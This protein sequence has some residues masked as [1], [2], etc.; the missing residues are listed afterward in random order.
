MLKKKG[1]LSILVTV[2]M[3]L[4]ACAAA[5]AADND[6]PMSF[7]ASDFFCT[8]SNAD[9]IWR[10][11]YKEPGY[12]YKDLTEPA[13]RQYF[14]AGTTALEIPVWTS[15]AKDVNR[16]VAISGD[17]MKAGYGNVER[18]A[19]RTFIA[20]YTGKVDISGI[21]KEYRENATGNVKILLNDNQIWP[22]ENSYDGSIDN[23]STETYPNIKD[24]YPIRYGEELDLS[25]QP[26]LQAV[27][28]NKGDEIHFTLVH[29]RRYTGESH[30]RYTRTQMNPT[31]TYTEASG[32]YFDK[33][34]G[35]V[36]SS[37]GEN[38]VLRAR[39]GGFD[40]GTA[41]MIAASYSEEKELKKAFV[42]ET[43]L[44]EK[45]KNKII[46]IMIPKSAVS[47]KVTLYL[48][49][50]TE[51]MVPIEE[52]T[53]VEIGSISL[54]TYASADAW[55][56]QTPGNDQWKYRAVNIDSSGR[57]IRGLIDMDTTKSFDYF[58]KEQTGAGEAWTR[59]DGA[60]YGAAIGEFYMEAGY[61]KNAD[62]VRSAVKQ[63]T[64]PY[65]GV[66]LI[67]GNA[68]AA[69]GKPNA[70]IKIMKNRNDADMEE[71][72][73]LIFP[74]AGSYTEEMAKQE[75]TDASLSYQIVDTYALTAENK[76]C[77][78]DD[79][80]L[81]VEVKAGDK[82]TFEVYNGRRVR[83]NAWA[84]TKTQWDPVVSYIER[85]G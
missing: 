68:Q 26:E 37:D 38:V 24:T 14:D 29:G 10:W 49:N 52:K 12:S 17:F 1:F 42:S 33:N 84:N 54:S 72:G 61:N 43:F 71:T 36:A 64:A 23:L 27:S 22:A 82:I 34:Y 81:R 76:V 21:V 74:A 56:T 58:N 39:V 48:W 69:T 8:D 9:A 18:F 46:N 79:M 75:I 32:V 83:D 63:F 3:S 65:D 20:P 53:T 70:N 50:S 85:I 15:D 67:T 7:K 11:Q 35:I 47:D 78:F 31:I 57:K 55:N 6:M 4:A 44:F 25:M 19:V 45:D 80:N 2:G 16:S 5:D 40:A 30:W 13:K 59:A 51:K 28:V 73:E 77:N 60:S 41:C 62:R 66:I